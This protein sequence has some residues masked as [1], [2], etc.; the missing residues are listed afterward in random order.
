MS[1]DRAKALLEMPRVQFVDDDPSH[2]E[3]RTSI[4]CS[5]VHETQLHSPSYAFVPR[6][7][8]GTFCIVGRGASSRNRITAVLSTKSTLHTNARSKGPSG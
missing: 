7:G 6:R 2:Y 8:R 4:V 3:Y 1:I 5:L